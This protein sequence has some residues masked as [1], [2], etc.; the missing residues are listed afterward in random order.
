[1]QVIDWIVENGYW[2]WLIMGLV[3]LGL[4]VLAPG[5]IFLWLAVAAAVTGIVVAVAAD[6]G[7]Q[8]QFG[9]FAATAIVAIAIGR[10]I[11]KARLKTTD[12]PNLNNRL[13]AY[14]G[15]EFTL[16]SAITNG[17]GEIKIGDTVWRVSGPDQ[18]AGNRVKV[19]ASDGALLQVEPSEA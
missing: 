6:I 13:D 4:E 8:W 5:V 2:A 10:P 19:I 15:R 3:L 16:T 11:Y 12:H 14:V 1:M 7:W 18:P 9:I 17:R